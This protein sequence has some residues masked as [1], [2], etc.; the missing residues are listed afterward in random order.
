MN[1]IQ[2]PLDL[3]STGTDKK[4]VFLLYHIVLTDVFAKRN[5]FGTSCVQVMERIDKGR[6]KFSHQGAILKPERLPVSQS[7]YNFIF[8]LYVS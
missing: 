6:L 7:I 5:T 1:Y 8:R 3:L 4:T 2:E